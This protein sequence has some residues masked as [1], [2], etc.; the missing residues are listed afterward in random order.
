MRK[1]LFIFFCVA[2][3]AFMLLS[4][5]CRKNK[6]SQEDKITAMQNELGASWGGLPPGKNYYFVDRYQEKVNG[7]VVYTIISSSCNIALPPESLLKY[8]GITSLVQEID[9]RPRPCVIIVN[10][11]LKSQYP[12]GTGGLLR[13]LSE[14]EVSEL[15]EELKKQN[16]QQ[17]EVEKLNWE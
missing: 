9:K 17:V 11:Y 5:G 8:T 4:V 12:K 15:K 13:E 1:L 14:D 7:Q 2:F 16:I 3:S 6:P 10:W